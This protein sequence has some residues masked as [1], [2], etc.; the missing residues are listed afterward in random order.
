MLCLSTDHV[1]LLGQVHTCCCAY[2]AA[3]PMLLLRSIALWRLQYACMLLTLLLQVRLLKND[4]IGNK[5]KKQAYLAA[6]M[7]ER[8]LCSPTDAAH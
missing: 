2:A 3:V 6:G 4:C 5:V 7:L 8:C 1:T